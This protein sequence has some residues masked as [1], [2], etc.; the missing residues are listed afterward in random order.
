MLWQSIGPSHLFICTICV[1]SYAVYWRFRFFFQNLSPDRY[2]NETTSIS[3]SDRLL[4]ARFRGTHHI[5]EGGPHLVH[6]HVGTG[7]TE[8]V[9]DNL[10][11]CGYIERFAGPVPDGRHVRERHVQQRRVPATP[12]WVVQQEPGVYLENENPVVYDGRYHDYR[13]TVR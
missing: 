1:F 7:T 10:C 3:G 13:C 8:S 2:F 6:P 11:G 12:P 5:H 9:D 4:T